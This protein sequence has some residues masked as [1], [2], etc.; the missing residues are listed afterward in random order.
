MKRIVVI[1]TYNEADNIRVISAGV[2][3]HEGFDALIVDDGSPDG[4]GG[5]A[6][7]IGRA[8]GGRVT[9]LHRPAKSGLG[10][11]YV[12]GYEWCLGHGYDMIAQMDADLS[13]DP[14][15]LPDLFAAAADGADVV[16]GSRYLNG[17][18]VINWPLRRILLSLAANEYVRRITGV[19]V[20]DATSGFRVY[21]ARALRA[22]S[23]STV[24]SSGYSFQ[25]EMTYRAFLCGARITEVPIIFTERRLGQSK[26]SKGVIMESALMPWRLVARRTS[27]QRQLGDL[28]QAISSLNILSFGGLANNHLTP[29]YSHCRLDVALACFVALAVFAGMSIWPWK[30][31]KKYS[32]DQESPKPADQAAREAVRGEP[33]FLA[34]RDKAERPDP[35]PT[36]PA[37][38]SGLPAAFEQFGRDT[39]VDLLVSYMLANPPRP[40]VVLGG[41]GM[42]K[43]T[44]AVAALHHARVAQRFRAHRYFVRLDG[45]TSAF[46]LVSAVAAELGVESSCNLRSA[47][48][49]HL[50]ATPALLVLD[51]L[52]TPWESDHAG[53]EL[54][55]ADLAGA[56]P[57]TSICA[58]IR[59]EDYPGSIWWNMPIQA[60]PLGP[61]DSR[62]LF[63]SVAGQ[64]VS[65]DPDM[66][67][68]LQELDGVPQAIHLLAK[69]AAGEASLAGVAQLWKAE[70][71]RLI[72]LGRSGNR[73]VSL[74]ASYELSIKGPKMS[75]PAR[76]FLFLLATLPDGVAN[77]DMPAVAGGETPA[78]AEEAATA[79]RGASLAFDEGGR[80]RLFSS[81]RDYVLDS[82]P[83]SDSDRSRAAG[84]YLEL[85]M[86]GAKPEGAGA[87]NTANLTSD[88]VNIAGSIEL[89]LMKPDPRPAVDAAGA[90]SEFY[91]ATGL[92]SV[93]LLDLAARRALEFGDTSRAAQS[94]L[95]AGGIA[96]LRIDHD[97]ARTSYEDALPL[98]RSIGDVVGE[99]NCIWKLGDIALYRCNYD[100]ARKN[101]E[102]GLALYRTA[103]DVRGE[104]NCVKSLGD[105]A[106][107]RNDHESAR[108]SYEEALPLYR[109]V[110]D[111]LGEANCIKCLGNIALHRRDHDAARLSYEEALPLYKHVGDV[112]G[113]ANCIMGLGNVARRRRD[114]EAAWMTYEEALPLFR[115]VGSIHGE[116]NCIQSLGDIALRRRD[117]K[118]ARKSYMAALELFERIQDPY[119]I[120]VTHWR[121]SRVAGEGPEHLKAARD[122]WL[123][124]GRQDLIDKY[125]DAPGAPD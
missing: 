13:H 58:S 94:Y 57:Q 36:K 53:T 30:R 75:V 6:E 105:I 124:I 2:L 66:A 51:N 89:E 102:D 115:R 114:H 48:F 23:V 54:F 29:S 39:K 76:N 77:G 47:V 90:I 11:A 52:E 38:V 59:G 88:A 117:Y 85:A 111:I 93:E 63:L 3:C 26:M 44:I 92:G 49:S 101:Y 104:A 106:Y 10:R 95:Q 46:G 7:E 17:I 72:D 69:R 67:G 80:I 1:P 64:D 15:S 14:R 78:E 99:A 19:P 109:S 108:K 98:Y 70:R 60:Q 86:L 42:G 121:L 100:L 84:H 45:A 18:S 71:K 34:G 116:A 83:P 24:K 22:M 50:A 28:R 87:S 56:A 43:T 110:A 113:E 16:V 55:L 5:I 103:H 79:L 12:E 20:H 37:S 8:S 61:A 33:Y 91:S 62:A 74:A 112:L 82:Y 40:S 68:L 65:S 118:W 73:L 120:G 25:V 9:V 119:S 125:L 31:N 96:L 35:E 97:S 122:A 81:L 21:T 41:P 32:L 4:T 123:S 27:L 107:E